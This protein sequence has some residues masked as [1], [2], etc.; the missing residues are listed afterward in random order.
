MTNNRG[1]NGGGKANHLGTVLQGYDTIHF[2][3]EEHVTPILLN[4]GI[5]DTT[6]EL[7]KYVVLR[8]V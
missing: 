2:Y 7:R 5:D 1:R 8:K 6:T 3:S 4:A